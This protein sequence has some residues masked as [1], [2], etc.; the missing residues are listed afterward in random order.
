MFDQLTS[1]RSRYQFR[2]WFKAFFYRL[3][4]HDPMED[5]IESEHLYDTVGLTV[6][7]VLAAIFTPF[8]IWSMWYIIASVTQ[9]E[10]RA[11]SAF[12]LTI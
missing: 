11:T 12:I 9:I 8:S 6:T 1:G 7:L 5:A 2:Q 3:C 4:V 10:V